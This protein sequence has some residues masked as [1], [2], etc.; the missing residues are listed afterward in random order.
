ML[1]RTECISQMSLL[2][3]NVLCELDESKDLEDAKIRVRGLDWLINHAAKG[4]SGTS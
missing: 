2:L 1:A 4:P 3:Q